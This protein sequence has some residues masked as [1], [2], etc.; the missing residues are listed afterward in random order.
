VLGS[1]EDT[2]YFFLSYDSSQRYGGG[3]F[4]E[5][6]PW[7]VH[8]FADLC[9]RVR[10]RIGAP[11]KV[12]VGFMD[13][14]P[15]S[16]DDWPVNLHRA[17]AACRVF[18]ALYSRDY[19][20]SEHCGREWSA[21]ARRLHD[22]A[23]ALQQLIIPVIWKPVDWAALPQAAQSIPYDDASVQA[24]ADHGCYGLIKLSRYRAA[25]ETT[26]DHL[27]A[28]IVAAAQS[29]TVTDEPVP[30]YIRPESAFG[31]ATAGERLLRITV[32]AP[33]TGDLPPGRDRS[34]YGPAPAD[35]APYRPG[36]P[37]AL[38]AQVSD[39]ARALG[40]RPLVGDLEERGAELLSGR[41]SAPELLIVDPWALLQDKCR[42]LLRR[43]DGM[44]LP[45]V[46]VIVPWNPQD[47]ETAAEDAKLRGTLTETLPEK[48]AEGK[49]T[50]ALA[51]LGVPTPEDLA[52]VLPPLIERAVREYRRHASARP[53]TGEVVERPRL[54]SMSRQELSGGE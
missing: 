30:Q 21:F 15:L 37:R 43:L 10:V 7:V 28:R 25:Y 48:L 29:V 4:S 50:S 6:D 36:S 47:A 53:P 20:A 12:S 38:A 5:V 52:Y 45:W 11:S 9:Y 14:A 1:A 39:R 40:Y 46:Q 32:A 35:W 31:A 16:G 54:L 34:Y 44:H 24:Y 41:P 3:D 18:V 17:L 49:A 33:S 8:F 13:R 26:L 23:E 27:A 22:R 42:D 2:P 51:V 19:F